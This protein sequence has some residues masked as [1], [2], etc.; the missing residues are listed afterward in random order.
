MTRKEIETAKKGLPSWMNYKSMTEEQKQTYKELKCR[1]MINSIL[2]YDGVKG[3]FDK[4]GRLCRYLRSYADENY[5]D[6]AHYY[7][8]EKRVLELIEEQKNDFAKAKVRRDVHTDYEGV[9]YNS[10]A[11]ADEM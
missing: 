3:L 6:A 1:E 5:R 2:I 11:W 10:I 9:S 4:D 8:S 7:I